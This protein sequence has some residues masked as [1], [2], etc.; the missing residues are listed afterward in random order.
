MSWRCCAQRRR[1]NS[2]AASRSP[3]VE[4]VP[5]RLG[6]AGQ[7]GVRADAAGDRVRFGEAEDAVLERALAGGDGGPQRGAQRGLEGGD[8][9]H[10]ALLKEAG[11][12]GHLAGIEQRMDDLPVGGVPADEQDFAGRRRRGGGG[13]DPGKTLRTRQGPLTEFG[14]LAVHSKRQ[15]ASPC[16]HFINLPD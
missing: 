14:R 10:H 1:N 2:S 4:D 8:V 7:V 12:V 5:D 15:I 6:L 13:W 11:E 3:E 16:Q 9:A